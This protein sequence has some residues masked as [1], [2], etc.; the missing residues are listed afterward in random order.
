MSLLQSGGDGPGGDSA[1]MASKRD[2]DLIQASAEGDLER[3]RLLVEK[4]AHVNAR[5]KSGT[6]PLLAAALSG[7]VG[8]VEALLAQGADLKTRYRNDAT[9]LILVTAR[10]DEAMLKLL[11]EKG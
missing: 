6:T 1:C 10:A 11:L 9:A 5:H 7:H 3:V 8:V 2:L 4:G